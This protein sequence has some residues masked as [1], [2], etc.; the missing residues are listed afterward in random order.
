MAEWQ[1]ACNS[2][3]AAA[4]PAEAA[5]KSEKAGWGFNEQCVS[6]QRVITSHIW[7]HYNF[8]CRPSHIIWLS[9]IWK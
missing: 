7:T 1:K 3:P 2:E 6:M 4:G 9:N 8:T 5:G